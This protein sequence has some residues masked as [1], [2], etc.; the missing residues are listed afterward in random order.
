MNDKYRVAVLTTA[1]ALFALAMGFAASGVAAQNAATVSSEDVGLA[2]QGDVAT[3]SINISADEGVT[4]ADTRI[5]VDTNVV[6]I[7]DASSQYEGGSNPQATVN[8][9]ND[10]SY[11]WINYTSIGAAA[12]SD[13]TVG[14][15]ELTAQTGAED[16]SAIALET[17]NYFNASNQ[18][19]ATVNTDERNATT[20]AG[21]FEVTNLNLPSSAQAGDEVDVSATVTNTNGAQITQDIDLLVNGTLDNST[22]VTLASG[23]STNVEFTFDT[24]GLAGNVPV[25]IASD[26]DNVT[27][28]I[29]VSDPGD[30]GIL[31]GDV[32]DTSGSRI[33]DAGGINVTITAEAE[34]TPELSSDV[35]VVDDIALADFNGLAQE[36]A[37]IDAAGFNNT[38]QDSY[39][40][41]LPT[42]GGEANYSIS[43]DLE[44]FLSFGGSK[45]IQ[46]GDTASQDIRLERIVNAD[47]LEVVDPTEDPVDVDPVDDS[48]DITTLVETEDTAPVGQL[49]PLAD[50]EVVTDVTAFDDPNGELTA[51]DVSINPGTT[52]TD[53]NGNAVFTVSLDLN[54]AGVSPGD[55]DQDITAEVEFEATNGGVTDTQNV[56]F[57]AEPPSGD[58]TI[59]GTVDEVDEDIPLGAD[60]I[61]PATGVNVHAVT[62]ERAA[63]NT[64][65]AT[66]FGF[67]FGE[68]SAQQAPPAMT[69]AADENVTVRL[70]DDDTGEILDVRTDYL[71][72]TPQFDGV[73][74]RQNTSAPGTGFDAVDT[75]GNGGEFGVTVL[76]DGEYTVQVSDDGSFDNPDTVDRNARNDLSYEATEERY[77]N[78]SAVPTDETNSQGDFELLNLYTEGEDG[79]SYVVI[80]GD[81]NA[82]VGFANAAGYGSLSVQ[83]NANPAAGNEIDLS[84]QE[85]GVAADTV[86]ATNVGTLPSADDVD[87]DYSDD[88][89]EFADTSDN[90]RQEVPRDNSTVDVIDLR[91]FV[92]EDDTNVGA[93]VTVSFT[94][95][96]RFDGDFLNTAV[97][98]T[99]E[100][101]DATTNEIT[102]DTGDNGEAAVFLESD[103]AALNDDVN[104]SVTAEIENIDTDTTLK[105]FVGVLDQ[106]YLS[107]SITGVVT[108]ENDNPVDAR[109]YV[110]EFVDQDA[111]VEVTFEPDDIGALDEF[112]A[113][114]TETATGDVIETVELTSNE[115]QNFSFQGFSSNLTLGAGEDP[116]QLLADRAADRTTLAPVPA[117]PEDLDPDDD[118]VS[119]ALRGVSAQNQTGTSVSTFVEVDR[120]S[121]ASV[122]IDAVET[123]FLL[124]GLSP[125]DATVQQGD[126]L[127]VSADVANIG[128]FDDTQEITLEVENDAGDVTELASQSVELDAG[129]TTT[130][131]F[132]VDNVDLAPGDY[133]HTVSSDDTSVSGNLTVEE[134]PDEATFEVSNLVPADA[135]VTEG[136]DPIDVT[137]DVENTGDLSGTQDV[138][139]E[140][141]NASG[142]VYS[143][144]VSVEL[145]AG[146]STTVEF[147]GVPAGD[148]APG[149]YTHT[150]SSDDTSVSGSL[151][152]EADDGGNGDT[153]TGP[154]PGFGNDDAPTDTDGDGLYEDINGD[155]QA[156][157]SEAVSLWSQL[158][159]N[160]G[161]FD[162]LTQEQVDALDFNGDGELSPA[163]A[164]SLW[165]DLVQ[166]Q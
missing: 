160:P 151:T 16:T 17:N 60:N 92:E 85:F 64:V 45:I 44:G 58:G 35:V 15:V 82:D 53:S 102:V 4:A 8:V 116:Y 33:S 20:G 107:G 162:D 118:R 24:S 133:T 161:Q 50:A 23:E 65:G 131:E 90:V 49:S 52:T 164:V 99:V 159:Q 13:F 132:N 55:L 93:T 36:Q 29:T 80:A 83:Q 42:F 124:T 126:S 106:E 105:E 30:R 130:V 156:T 78:V 142:V 94:A 12:G 28:T 109:V 147:T 57:V 79:K 77:S 18:P 150:V 121:T 115:M 137:A 108:D 135:N 75:D 14:Q 104:V 74:L 38:G 122:V 54:G 110:T 163:D 70:V 39:T 46:Q 68:P 128:D 144:T 139:L 40:I 69:L 34:D 113:T 21:F 117:V 129:G 95:P 125:E 123:E 97:N 146:N 61:E 89:D 141:T 148:L 66:G 62:V 59:S 145:D 111:G 157:P 91:T 76:E 32:R 73:A 101:Y 84:V 143:D 37:N 63:Q 3:S 119:Y 31:T 166:N 56:T 25:E 134:A 47:N 100:N 7:S 149:D 86:D 5:S 1:V 9:S 26:D 72:S 138:A 81:G 2:N 67:G 71:F 87:A 136:D 11:A 120:T 127:T 140:V 19:F 103:D 153:F 41:N 165:S 98:G 96:T 43:A 27:G 154:L 22:T 6:N 152:V 112:T 51:G 88:L 158:V 155:G 10:G 114:V 48:V